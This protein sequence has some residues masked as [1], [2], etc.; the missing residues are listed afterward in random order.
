MKPTFIYIL[1]F[2]PLL[3]FSQSRNGNKIFAKGYVDQQGVIYLRWAPSSYKVWTKLNRYGYEVIRYTII[4]DKKRLIPPPEKHLGTFMPKELLQWQK[5]VETNRNAAILAQALYGESFQVTSQDKLSAI[6]SMSEEQQQRF[7]WGLYAADQDFDV[8]QMAGLAYVDKDTNKNEKYLY[9]IRSLVPEN[10]LS[11]EEGVVYL[12]F[13]DYTNLPKPIDFTAQFIDKSV[14]LGWNGDIYKNYYS[15]YVIEKSKDGKSF[16]RVNKLPFNS[17]NT[18]NNKNKRIYYVDSIPNNVKYYYRVKGKTIFGKYSPPSDVLS[19]V[20]KKTL[21]YMP[22]FTRQKIQKDNKSVLLGWKFPEKAE[23]LIKG[24]VISRSNKVNGK[25]IDV[26]KDIPPKKRE[27]LYKGLQNSNYFTITALGKN[28]A[29]R[30]SFAVFVQPIDSIPPVKP[31]GLR[32]KIDS[33][34]VVTLHWNANPDK[35][36]LGYRVFRANNENEEMSQITVSPHRATVF[37]DSIG[38]HNLNKYVYYKIIAVDHRYNMSESSD[39][40][41]LKKPDFIPPSQ[42][43]FKHYDIKGNSITIEWFN[44]PDKDVVRH[45]LWR[46]EQNKSWQLVQGFKR[47]E[48]PDKTTGFTDKELTAGLSYD[49]KVVAIDDSGL[50]SQT[51]EVLHL[52]VPKTVADKRVKRFH[53]RADKN[54]GYIELFW[55]KYK[56]DDLAYLLLYKGIKDKRISLLRK[57]PPQVSYYKDTQ[58]KP[59]N[60]YE[61]IIRPV[62]KNNIPGKP[63][64]IYVKY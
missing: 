1:F 12:G 26:I 13:D 49:Y 9:K 7:T 14:M 25:Y 16:T 2:I 59:N 56:A 22:A 53:A 40:L 44:S 43:V 3:I 55:K 6:V 4:R 23:R 61:Y 10:I 5:M 18:V 48:K 51:P 46:K 41:Q 39:K 27:V 21:Q 64:T 42:P 33:L 52:Q 17:L 37:Y 36:I 50:Q 34:G 57:L 30:T 19:G 54:G 47:T 31:T 38:V 58:L 45:E 15:S 32:G 24:F 63:E 8:A 29:K 35:D 60:V 28:G 11:I 62:F 20:A